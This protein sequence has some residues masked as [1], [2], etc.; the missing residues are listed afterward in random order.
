M[1]RNLKESQWCKDECVGFIVAMSTS[2]AFLPKVTNKPGFRNNSNIVLCQSIDA[3]GDK[4]FCRITQVLSFVLPTNPAR[5]PS[6]VFPLLL[7][8]FLVFCEGPFFA[9]IFWWFSAVF[10]VRLASSVPEAGMNLYMFLNGECPMSLR[11]S[12][13]R[14]K[15]SINRS[16]KI[17]EGHLGA[18]MLCKIIVLGFLL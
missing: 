5:N 18:F 6:Q 12:V 13:A 10:K 14:S 16:I 3:P 15:Q 7:V 8:S 11:W 17:G 4:C 9:K 2:K 1:R